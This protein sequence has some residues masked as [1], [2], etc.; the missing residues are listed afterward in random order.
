MMHSTA[1]GAS[2][3]VGVKVGKG[4]SV[5]VRIGVFVSSGVLV[6]LG[7]ISADIH[8]ESKK[9]ML[10]NADNLFIVLSFSI[11]TFPLL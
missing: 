7:G 11:F 10:I 5:S 4:V 2:V 9:I 6:T 3:A 8:E 1:K